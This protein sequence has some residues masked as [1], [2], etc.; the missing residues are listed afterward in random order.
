[1]SQQETETTHPNTQKPT[2][3]KSSNLR[4]R[5]GKASTSEVIIASSIGAVDDLSTATESLSGKKPAAPEAQ[6]KE[7]PQATEK[8]SIQEEHKAERQT[9]AEE[10]ASEESKLDASPSPTGKARSESK[11]H[12]HKPQRDHSAEREAAPHKRT[13][14]LSNEKLDTFE[15]SH[16]PQTWVPSEDDDPTPIKRSAAYPKPTRRGL[17]SRIAKAFTDWFSSDTPEVQTVSNSKVKSEAKPQQ[18]ASKTDSD[19]PTRKPGKR[20]GRSRQR[21][22][23]GNNGDRQQP[24]NEG[25]KREQAQGE[26][27]GKRRRG[28]RGGRNRRRRGGGQ[29]RNAKPASESPQE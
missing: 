12:K 19:R 21:R 28:S 11:P 24:R 26:E 6:K 4:S 10:I 1:M 7:Q 23:G 2:S 17:L 18:E 5:W 29:N 8:P 15:K 3:R 14:P 9:A 20:G 25:E 16:K 13:A 22:Q 27:R